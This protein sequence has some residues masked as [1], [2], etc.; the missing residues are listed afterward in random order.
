METKLLSFHDDFDDQD[1]RI[2][3]EQEMLERGLICPHC[4][5]RPHRAHTPCGALHTHGPLYSERCT[6]NGT[7]PTRR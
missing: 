5:H 6:C 3:S 1:D 2:V 7:N 4:G